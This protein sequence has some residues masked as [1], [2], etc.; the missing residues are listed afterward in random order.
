MITEKRTHK[1][2]FLV[3]T[4]NNIKMLFDFF[5][6][7]YETDQEDHSKKQT[8]KLNYTLVCEDGTSY[9][10]DTIDLIENDMPIN[11]KHIISIHM[12][13][14]NYTL[15]KNIDLDLYEN[16]DRSY[17]RIS[18]RDKNWV[19]GNFISFQEILNS[20]KPQVSFVQKYKKLITHL[21][22]IGI[23]SLIFILLDIFI[24]RFTELI[25]NPSDN[26]IGLRNFLSL[27]PRLYYL[28]L[29]FSR[30]SIGIPYSFRI[31]D[32]WLLTLWPKIEFEFGPDHFKI[33]EKRRKRVIAISGFIIPIIVDLLI[34]FI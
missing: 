10:S 31:V 17:F 16:S 29:I 14:W 28:L 21:L 3:F 34:T 30:W 19:Q 32:D 22:A 13:Y 18:G 9:E 1:I 7:N 27:N 4:K 11:T 20:V 2:N 8:C 15:D 12:E 24:F 5:L 23:G 6:T 25:P 33:Y 26:A